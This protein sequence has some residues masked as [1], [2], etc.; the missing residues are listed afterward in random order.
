MIDRLGEGL[1]VEKKGP[2]KRE[3]VGR[4]VVSSSLC[5]PAVRT[6]VLQTFF[7]ADEVPQFFRRVMPVLA[8]ES[9]IVEYY[10]KSAYDEE[11]MGAGD[12]T[13]KFLEECG[14]RIC[15]REVETLPIY[16]DEE[17]GL[18]SSDDDRPGSNGRFMVVACPW[19]RED[20]EK[21]FEPLFTGMEKWLKRE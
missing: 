12:S 9:R 19:P 15:S 10:V 16:A 8:I 14:Y 20:D 7:N 13:R 21:Q 6:V 5:P 1:R 3:L 2:R 11:A 4:H 17:L 18:C